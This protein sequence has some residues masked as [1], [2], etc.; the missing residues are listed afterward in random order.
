MAA[1]APDL[2]S[3]FAAPSFRGTDFGGLRAIGKKT[4][5]V[6]SMTHLLASWLVAVKTTNNP[7]DCRLATLAGLLPDAD[8]LGLVVDVA[9][10]LVGRQPTD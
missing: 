1:P 3:G 7:R 2:K 9:N 4:V 6:S 10:E 8:G 5:R